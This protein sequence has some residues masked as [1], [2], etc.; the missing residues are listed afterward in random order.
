MP[1]PVTESSELDEILLDFFNET[2]QD[3]QA[4]NSSTVYTKAGTHAKAKLK[5]LIARERQKAVEE[6]A[7]AYG[8][9]TNCYG[10]GYSTVIQYATGYDTDT[11]IG[12]PGGKIHF[13]QDP[14][15]LCACE[16][17]EQLKRVLATQ[18]NKG[19]AE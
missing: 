4:T 19:E 6:T 14:I 9:C 12:S 11:D 3:V 7:K 2:Y 5:D 10:K 8:G 17:G 13:R 16:R 15:K 18:S 1:E